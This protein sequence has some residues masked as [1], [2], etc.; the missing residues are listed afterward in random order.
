MTLPK[1][2]QTPGPGPQAV[3]PY[4]AKADVHAERKKAL[5]TAGGWAF[6]AIRDACAEAFGQTWEFPEFKA[7]Y[8]ATPEQVADQE[9]LLHRLRDTLALAAVALDGLDPAGAIGVDVRA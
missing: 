8:P 5:G 6:G 2:T 4:P 7:G 3:T 9:R 1:N